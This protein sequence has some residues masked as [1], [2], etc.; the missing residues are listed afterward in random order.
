MFLTMPPRRQPQNDAAQNRAPVT[1]NTFLNLS[2]ARSLPTS[3]GRLCPREPAGAI[4]EESNVALD[5]EVT[6]DNHFATLDPL[7]HHHRS[8]DLSFKLDLPKFLDNLAPKEFLD[9]F[10]VV[11]ELFSYKKVS[12]SQRVPLFCTRLRGR[13]AATKS[14]SPSP[15]I[16]RIF[17]KVQDL[18][19]FT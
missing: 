1:D 7:Q 13:T 16:C 2:P 4:L 5:Y 18:L 11:D 19:M 9:W 6:I 12:S 17:D 10:A 3:S 15:G 8:H 14:C